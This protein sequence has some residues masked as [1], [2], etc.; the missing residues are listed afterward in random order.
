[1][2]RQRPL[3]PELDKEIRDDRIASRR[4]RV[5]Q[6]RHW[7]RSH[8]LSWLIQH[9]IDHGPKTEHRLMH[10]VMEEEFMAEA[11]CQRGANVLRALY[12]L[13]LV[14]KLWR[15]ETGIHPGS[16]EMSYLY[17]IRGVHPTS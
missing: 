7:L 13:W 11:A 17:G 9:L 10:E 15:R 5:Q 12:A 14:K 2:S 8:D 4:E 6:A 1:M 3:F 16:G